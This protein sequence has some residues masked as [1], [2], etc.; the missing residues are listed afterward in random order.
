MSIGDTHR[1]LL[2][3]MR[4]LDRGMIDLGFGKPCL[5]CKELYMP[6]TSEMW[7]EYFGF[8]ST[9]CINIYRRNQGLPD[10]DPYATS[11]SSTSAPLPEEQDEDPDFEAAWQ[12]EPYAEVPVPL[13]AAPSAYVKP[14]PTVPPAKY[15]AIKI[16]LVLVTALAGYL[17]F[18]KLTGEKTEASA[19]SEAYVTETAAPIAS[20]EVSSQPVNEMFEVSSR[21]AFFYTTPQSTIPR[22]E[23]LVK[24]DQLLAT[25]AAGDFVFTQFT[26][27]S[28]QTTAGWLRRSDL[29]PSEQPS[30]EV[31]AEGDDSVPVAETAVAPEET[32][33][34]ETQA[35][36]SVWRGNVG[37][38]P[39]TFS[40]RWQSD[41]TV[42]GSYFYTNNPDQ[43]Y[44][45]T[46]RETADGELELTEYTGE[47]E[48]ATCHLTLA[49]DCYSGTMDNTDG[50]T[51]PMKVCK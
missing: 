10:F 26:N 31:Q 7:P 41:G 12:E 38:A 48:S 47:Q 1:D 45:L 18:T 42:Q 23:Y 51:L 19:S 8:C 15:R 30:P 29:R 9:P 13:P 4:S 11:R 27:P 21:R 22:G 49:D 6:R 32:T 24:G 5:V 14:A 17:L 20:A 36:P 43:V 33:P 37:Q 2:R 34:D 44:T 25:Q 40:L 16:A 46:G 3:S 35:Q 50:R 39:A 28:G